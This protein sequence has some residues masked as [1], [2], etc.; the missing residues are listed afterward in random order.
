[1]KKLTT[2]LVMLLFT[3]GMAIGQNTANTPQS[4]NGNDSTIDQVG[5]QNQGDT[6]QD[7]NGNDA[8]LVQLE[9]SNDGGIQQIGNDNNSEMSQ[10]GISNVGFS[11]Q[12][13]DNS[14]NGNRNVSSLE[15]TGNNNEGTSYQFYG[16]ENESEVIQNG[17]Q[18]LAS[19]KQGSNLAGTNLFDVVNRNDAVITQ[20][21]SNSVAR[22][23]QFDGDDNVATVTQDGGNFNN[24]QIYQGYLF[25]SQEASPSVAN[26]NEGYID[27]VGDQNSATVMQLGGYNLF[28]L[29]QTG[30]GNTVG[31]EG[32][33]Q[34][35]YNWFKQ[36][37]DRNEFVGVNQG[38]NGLS[39]ALF[40]AAEQN[41]GATL[42]FDSEGITGYY[43]SFQRGNDNSIG[44]RQGNNDV[45]QI[46]QLGNSNTSLLYQVGAE[47]HSA[48]ILQDGNSNTASVSQTSN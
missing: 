39:L 12:G 20:N 29:V 7:G 9:S 37:G 10:D 38:S 33:L 26:D 14:S 47:S 40:S 19:V 2:L 32:A 34:S 25:N 42:D 41:N 46:Q 11:L 16:V 45:G 4:G 8:S 24:G 48:T 23:R 18:N 31:E 36:R 27:Q 6:E 30:T 3:A 21:T 44:L 17:N 1:M 28:N 35:G 5:A 13:F 15:Q 43:G 22:I